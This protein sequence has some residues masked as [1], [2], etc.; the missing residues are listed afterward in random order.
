MF[1]CCVAVNEEAEGGNVSGCGS[2]RGR[3]VAVTPLL[4][5]LGRSTAQE[6][7]RNMNRSI[8]LTTLPIHFRNWVKPQYRNYALG[9]SFEELFRT[10][11]EN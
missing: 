11:G 1:H 4:L 5:F 7:A 2:G 10:F 9:R 8:L 3:S 6:P